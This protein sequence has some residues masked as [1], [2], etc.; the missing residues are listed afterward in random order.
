MKIH[1][2]VNVVHTRPYFAQPEDIT[3]IIQARPVPVPTSQGEE[4]VVE[5][6]LKHRK[7]EHAFQFLTLMKE[8]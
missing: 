2:V 8:V 7:G 3:S 1:K 5:S 4:Y 6:I